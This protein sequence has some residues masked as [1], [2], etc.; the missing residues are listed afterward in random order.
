[1]GEKLEDL[2]NRIAAGDPPDTYVGAS[3]NLIIALAGTCD[4]GTHHGHN[5]VTDNKAHKGLPP[6]T[7]QVACAILR[8]GHAHSISEAIAIA[9]GAVHNW[10]QGHTSG[11]SKHG[12]SE[13]H[14]VTPKVQAEATADDATW[15]S[16]KAAAH[17]SGVAH[18][19]THG[20]EKGLSYEDSKKQKE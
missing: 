9:R 15:D 3:G 13:P 14:H 5:W 6:K 4:L 18:K 7:H 10:S 2:L 20:L 11:L 12:V 1:M 19:I 17:A 16:M 8:D